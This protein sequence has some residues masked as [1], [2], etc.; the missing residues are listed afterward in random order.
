MQIMKSHKRV[1][2]NITQTK[3]KQNRKLN[4]TE[5]R[6]EGPTNQA[7]AQGL[8]ALTR[9]SSSPLLKIRYPIPSPTTIATK[10]PP[11]ND[12]T[13]SISIYPI[14]ELTV[15]ITAVA[16]LARLHPPSTLEW[17]RGVSMDGSDEAGLDSAK[18]LNRIRRSS[19]YW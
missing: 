3:I 9:T 15:K 16:S 11:L 8:S 2:T 5:Q 12:I 4:S 19:M 6:E 7:H 14:A 13:A 17:R 1:H 10:T 18:I